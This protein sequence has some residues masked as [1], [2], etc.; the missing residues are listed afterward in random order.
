MPRG[1]VPVNNTWLK[2]KVPVNNFSL[3]KQTKGKLAFEDSSWH[4]IHQSL[5][6]TKQTTKYTKIQV[7]LQRIHLVKSNHLAE[8]DISWENK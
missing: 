1:T 4:C 2:E 5:L 6:A 8:E 3:D 7:F